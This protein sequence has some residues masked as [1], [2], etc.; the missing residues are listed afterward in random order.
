MSLPRPLIHDHKNNLNLFYAC[1]DRVDHLSH[2]DTGR[3]HHHLHGGIKNRRR[4]GRCRGHLREFIDYLKPLGA[5]L[6]APILLIG[7]EP[8]DS[9]RIQ[10]RKLG[11]KLTGDVVL[12]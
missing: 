10:H 4:L 1:P 12:K 8:F 3:G 7:L 5:M 9:F 6:T 2:S 11:S